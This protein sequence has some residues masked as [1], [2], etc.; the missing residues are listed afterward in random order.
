MS[1]QLNIYVI[2]NLSEH[3]NQWNMSDIKKKM[4]VFNLNDKVTAVP[5]IHDD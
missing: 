2:N 1:S 4:I 5:I 3:L